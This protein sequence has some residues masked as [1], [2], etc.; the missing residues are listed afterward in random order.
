MHGRFSQ[1]L[2]GRHS[3]HTVWVLPRSPGDSLEEGVIMRHTLLSLPPGEV[4]EAGPSQVLC[5]PLPA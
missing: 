1:G 5:P 2:Q 3:S 4:H